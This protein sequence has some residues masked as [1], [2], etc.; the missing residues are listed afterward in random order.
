MLLDENEAV[1][2]LAA[3]SFCTLKNVCT[4]IQ[5][6][7]I[8][9]CSYTISQL[10]MTRRHSAYIHLTGNWLKKVLRDANTALWL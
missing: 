1:D 9:L 3:V 5:Q 6:N 10:E 4:K 8:K 7:T 2:F